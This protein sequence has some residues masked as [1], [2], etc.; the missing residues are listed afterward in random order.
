MISEPVALALVDHSVVG[1]DYIDVKVVKRDV[2][3][4]QAHRVV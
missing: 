4:D 2:G 1:I 3:V